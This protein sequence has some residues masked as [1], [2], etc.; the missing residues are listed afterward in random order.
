MSTVPPGPAIDPAAAPTPSYAPSPPAAAPGA[1]PTGTGQEEYVQVQRSQLGD[2]EGD[3]HA[4]LKDARAHRQ[5]KNDGWDRA[6]ATLQEQGLTG[7]DLIRYWEQVPSQEQAPAAPPAAGQPAPP[8]ASQ[9]GA[10][11]TAEMIEQ[12]FE[13]RLA[14]HDQAAR[15]QASKDKAAEQDRATL[16]VAIEA[17]NT[18]RD[19]VI[20]DLKFAPGKDGKPPRRAGRARTWFNAVLNET[21]AEE[22]PAHWPQKRR[23][24][25]MK[26]PAT[27]AQLQRARATFL[28]DHA[29]F[30]NE[31]AAAIARG[32]ADV[33]PASL[34]GAPSG[35]PPKKYLE[36]MS[37]DERTAALTKQ[38]RERK[39]K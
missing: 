17:E 24:E 18:F 9:A 10:P 30:R 29:D 14:A 32:D 5:L 34:G 39:R 33:P 15:E 26:M 35:G 36:Q 37:R 4:A 11:A 23:D 16:N 2:W 25:A 28:A 13:R 22:I 8:A 21:I 6:V 38:M 1:A 31:D 19:K 20:A 27:D 12:I 7:N 3:Y